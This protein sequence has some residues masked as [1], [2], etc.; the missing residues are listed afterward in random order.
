MQ[1]VFS[2]SE[3]QAMQGNLLLAI[4]DFQDEHGRTLIPYQGSCR[5]IGL[6]AW[7]KYGAIIA[8]Q[9]DGAYT[10]RLP[11]VVLMN[12]TTYQEHFENI[13]PEPVAGE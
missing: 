6:D 9:F 11:K 3:A 1:E 5:V 12:K 2:L 10:Q 13:S 8:V 4:K 7:D